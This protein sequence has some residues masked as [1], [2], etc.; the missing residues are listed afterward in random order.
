MPKE[1]KTC[2]KCGKEFESWPSRKKQFCSRECYRESI[3]EVKIDE[4][5]KNKEALLK[6]F[7]KVVFVVPVSRGSAD[8]L[9]REFQGI[10]GLT[11]YLVATCD[12]A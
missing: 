1:L 10:P 3:L 4:S 7:D 12:Q 5:E 2:I 9:T 11:Y 8:K 6:N